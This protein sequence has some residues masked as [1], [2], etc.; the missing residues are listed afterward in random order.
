MPSQKGLARPPPSPVAAA[1]NGDGDDEDEPL[2]RESILPQ[3]YSKDSLGQSMVGKL[4]ETHVLREFKRPEQDASKIQFF[5]PDRARKTLGG[6]RS[7]KAPARPPALSLNL[8]AAAS[9]AEEP[10]DFQFEPLVLWSPPDEPELELVG[11]GAEGVEA[12][13][14][15]DAGATDGAAAAADGGAPSAEGAADGAAVVASAPKKAKERPPPI[16]VDPKLCR[17]LR[18]HQR[19]G[20]QFLFDCLMG[21]REYD[22]CG[23]ILAD[24]MGLGKTLQSITI[25][26]TLM[27]QGMEGKP[28]VTHTIVACPV[29]LVTNWESE[30][31]KKWIGSDR[32]K[33]R[34]IDVIGV[35]EASKKEV[36]AMVQR[37][38]YARSAVLVISYETFR[39]HE[40]LF[41]KGNQC[42]YSAE[43]SSAHASTRARAAW[44]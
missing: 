38:S 42:G 23:C 37:F 12:A 36:K 19:E 10:D 3:L 34:G 5:D 9:K 29:S 28:A 30:L 16:S 25:L 33:A 7:G 1:C 20:T 22:G 14:A 11:E 32:L 21:L 2:F 31:N 26:W 8:N 44:L 43:C 35:S 40:K 27:T 24:D 13:A 18:S 6:F 15:A 4:K 39:I 41:K 17:F